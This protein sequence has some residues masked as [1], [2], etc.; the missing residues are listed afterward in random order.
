MAW[1]DVL[2]LRYSAVP[3]IP[4]SVMPNTLPVTRR[5]ILTARLDVSAKWEALVRSIGGVGAG[6]FLNGGGA[7][8]AE[9]GLFWS[10]RH[11]V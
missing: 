10:G 7:F 4:S 1:L 2:A 9:G 6:L 8:M 5:V 3:I 11:M